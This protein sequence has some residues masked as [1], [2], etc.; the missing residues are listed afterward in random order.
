[1]KV[2]IAGGSN[3][4]DFLIGMLL[5]SKRKLLV[6]NEDP[7]LCEKLS[8]KHGVPVFCGDPAKAFVLEEAGVKNFDVIIA[9]TPDDADN[10]VIGQTA[11]K[12]FGVKKAVCLVQNPKNVEIF[13]KLGINTAI[14]AAYMI[15]DVIAQA[16]NL[17][18]LVKTMTV[19]DKI[20]LTEITTEEDC[21]MAGRLIRDVKMPAGIIV[22]C[23]IRGE[24]MVV[25]GGNTEIRAGDKLMFLSAP[26]D[27]NKIVRMF[28][29]GTKE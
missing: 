9:L 14:S 1:M 18:D 17:E 22:S 24:D 15:A 19:E 28:A 27:Q 2:C 21:P 3:E 10:L 13:K 20:I 5:K 4:A 29:R 7:A 12:R 25:P 8:G 23:I 26:A 11:K 6:I 16:S